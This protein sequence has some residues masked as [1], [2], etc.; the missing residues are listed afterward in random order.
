MA[1]EHELFR[2]VLGTDFVCAE[3]V[4]KQDGGG[5]FA[6]RCRPFRRGRAS[7]QSGRMIVIESITASPP[8]CTDELLGA[9]P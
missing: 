5:R 9:H 7:G 3:A 6:E 1:V 4:A 8:V 2:E